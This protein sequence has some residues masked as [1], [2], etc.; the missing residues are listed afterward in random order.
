MGVSVNAFWKSWC[1]GM[2]EATRDFIKP[3][4]RL[5]RAIRS[6]FRAGPPRNSKPDP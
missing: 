1:Q 6:L 3:T 2:R 4:L 5:L